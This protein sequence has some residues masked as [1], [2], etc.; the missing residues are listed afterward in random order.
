[1]LDLLVLIL[2]MVVFFKFLGFIFNA[3]GIILG[4]ILGIIGYLF[5][6]VLAVTA[7]GMVFLVFPVILIAGG[8]A[9]ARLILR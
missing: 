6:A 9:I 1:M 2:L 7:F 4:G 5:L 8:I 3:A